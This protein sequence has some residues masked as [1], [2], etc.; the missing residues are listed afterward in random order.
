[1]NALKI[2][3]AAFPA[4]LALAIRHEKTGLYFGGFDLMFNPIWSDQG[5]AC[6]WPARQRAHVIAQIQLLNKANAW[7]KGE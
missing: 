3:N 7:P 2:D 4:G 6:A 1:M 5:K